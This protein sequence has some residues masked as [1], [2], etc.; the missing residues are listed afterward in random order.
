MIAP[1]PAEPVATEAAP[2]A[3]APSYELRI[4]PSSKLS[5]GDPAEL[6]RYRDLLFI[7][8][9]RDFVAKYKQ[10][11]LGPIWFIILPLV[12]TLIFTLIFGKV[13]R[14][15]TD[16]L[17]PFLFF[18]C[19]QVIWGYFSANYS[20]VSGTL[21]GNQHIFSK[22]YFPRLVPPVASLISNGVSL[23]IQFV[24][25]IAFYLYSKM[26]TSAGAALTPSWHLVF[27]PVLILLA[28]VQGLGFGL[29]MAAIT[30]KYRDLQH[31]AGV[32]IQLWMY[33]S[34]VIFPLS[35][36]PENYR[37]LVALNPITFLTESFRF[38]LLGQG[39][40]SWSSGLYAVTVSIAVLLAGLVVFD[41]TARKFIDIV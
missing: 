37:S 25:L 4:R 40:L 9:W 15:S 30:A 33:G 20:T 18:L 21:L 22:V 27:V 14:M 12:S 23:A 2:S 24:L 26:G 8:V 16:G 31:V 19:N 28:A 35:Q 11:I 41:R 29:W 7:L 6:W 3:I 38:C 17:P 13:A 1:P 32:I 5:F 36:I 10:T 34:A 39:T